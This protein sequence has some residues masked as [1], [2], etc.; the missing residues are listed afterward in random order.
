MRLFIAIQLSEEMKDTL[1]TMQSEL[2]S[3]GVHGNFTKRDNLHLT[4]AFIGEYDDA[5]NVLAVINSTEL[6]PFTMKLSGAGTF[7]KLWWVGID[8]KA[9]LTAYTRRLRKALDEAGIP[10]D[11]KR[12]R[13]HITLIRNPSF[14]DKAEE[15]KILEALNNTDGVCMTVEHISLMRSDRGENGMIYTEIR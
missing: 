7:H 1:Q 15:T 9:A 14:S 3:L 2:R 11:N 6:R 4:L 13:P 5:E 12:F 10:Y 8:G